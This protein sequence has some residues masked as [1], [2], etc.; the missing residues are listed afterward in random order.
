MGGYGSD[1]SYDTSDTVTKKSAAA[2]NVDKK[3]DYK[4]EEIKQLPP[5]KSKILVTNS[6]FPVVIAVDV[7]GSMREYP[8]M[9]F[10]KLCILY[11]EAL[12][13]LPPKLKNTFEIS[14]AAV[15]D[16]YTD[17]YPL[18]VTDF[19]KGFELDKNIKT[20]YP[21]GGGGGQARESYE[22]MGYYYATHCELHKAQK[23]PR[24]MFFYIGDEGYYTKVNREQVSELISNPPKTDVVSS[25]MF[26]ELKKKFDVY[27]LRIPYQN[28]DDE[29]QI[30]QAWIDV[31]GKDRVIML[32][33]PK[34]VVDTILGLIAA[35]VDRFK[36]FKERIEVRQTSE[37]VEQVYSTLNGLQVDDKKYVY[38]FQTLTCPA[39]GGAMDKIPD[40]GKPERCPFCN[41][42]IVRIEDK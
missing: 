21:E 17:G 31:L 28:Q 38:K 23:K 34:R 22:L 32:P 18:Q 30:H 6:L 39:C 12:F 10:E 7:T 13:F 36:E 33:D 42:L 5:P 37:Q 8:K 20:L 27:M 2:Y 40:Y 1:Y 24:P 41:V 4:I 3:R 25:D 29:V 9:I 15:G 35:N 16:A 14:F 11:N 19:G 26:D